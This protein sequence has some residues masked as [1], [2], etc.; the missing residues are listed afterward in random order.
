MIQGSFSVLPMKTIRT[1]LRD[2][3][4]IF[5]V[6]QSSFGSADSGHHVVQTGV[7]NAGRTQGR[8]ALF[9]VLEAGAEFPAGVGDAG[10]ALFVA[11]ATRI[12]RVAAVGDEGEHGLRFSV[13]PLPA[14]PTWKVNAGEHFSCPECL[15]RLH[16]TS[17]RNLQSDAVAPGAARLQ[18]EAESRALGSAARLHRPHA[19]G[20]PVAGQVQASPCAGF[21]TGPPDER[22]VGEHPDVAAIRR[23]V[24]GL[25]QTPRPSAGVERRE[26]SDPAEGD[27]R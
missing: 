22:G 24:E 21:E 16:Q 11:E 26:G 18:S 13:L 9:E 25:A 12:L 14:K 1:G 6:R 5:L 20:P 27:G 8:Y 15:Q 7:R 3:R 17:G 2:S 4:G 23:R 19:E 10:G